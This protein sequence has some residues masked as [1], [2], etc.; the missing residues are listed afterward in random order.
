MPWMT[1]RP[2]VHLLF[3]FTHALATSASSCGVARP[4]TTPTKR[5]S[6]AAHVNADAATNRRVLYFENAKIAA[7]PKPATSN[8][9]SMIRT[10][11]PAFWALV[12]GRRG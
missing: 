10:P 12:I 7:M 1:S 11:T 2:R 3:A 6:P 8:I 9:A 4:L 5:C